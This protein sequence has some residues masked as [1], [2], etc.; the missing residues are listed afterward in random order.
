MR[1]AKAERKCVKNENVE[2]I[3]RKR[4]TKKRC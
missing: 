2:G 3:I 4:G 1:F